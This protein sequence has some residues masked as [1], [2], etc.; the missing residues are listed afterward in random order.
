[1]RVRTIQWHGRW[2]QRWSKFRALWSLQAA[3]ADTS[4]CDIN[5][6]WWEVEWPK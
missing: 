3:G 4:K 5:F 1:M 2:P 6:D